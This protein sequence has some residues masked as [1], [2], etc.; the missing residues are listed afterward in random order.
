[1]ANGSN[2]GGRGGSGGIIMID[3]ASKNGAGNPTGL[4]YSMTE[5]LK[6]IVSTL[7]PAGV[8]PEGVAQRV[9]R[10]AAVWQRHARTRRSAGDASGDDSSHLQGED[11]IIWDLLK[12]WMVMEQRLAIQ[13]DDP[14][15]EVSTKIGDHVV[16]DGLQQEDQNNG[17][18]H[19]VA[20]MMVSEYLIPPV[21][22]THYEEF[23][24]LPPV[25]IPAPNSKM[26]QVLAWDV[27]PKPP[28]RSDHSEY[29]ETNDILP[30][31]AISPVDH[32]PPDVENWD[33]EM[34]GRDERIVLTTDNYPEG[35]TVEPEGWRWSRRLEPTILL[36]LPGN[37]SESI[38]SPWQTFSDVLSYRGPPV[39][40]ID[41]IVNTDMLQCQ[42][43][44][45]TLVQ[46]TESTESAFQFTESS[47]IT[48]STQTTQSTDYTI[49]S[50]TESNSESPTEFILST[51][52]SSESYTESTT[53]PFTESTTEFS[54][55]TA[56]RFNSETTTESNLESTTE[57]TT[58]S[59][60]YTEF[61]TESTT[62][63][64]SIQTIQTI[65]STDL[66]TETPE[67]TGPSETTET[68]KI[69]ATLENFETATSE[70][71]TR[72]VT[73]VATSS[74]ATPSQTMRPIPPILILEGEPVAYV[75][76]QQLLYDC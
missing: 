38:L 26:I 73:T 1:M 17:N 58:E 3:N 12:D 35:V 45:P 25:Q 39:D 18:Q 48:E 60:L 75:I 33:D 23:I 65:Q 64:E 44:C 11:E 62:L 6:F 76:Y 27:E 15:R 16:L 21:K 22:D 56:T 59:T 67:T 5:V 63:T 9:D 10:L 20:R 69:L 49:E 7:D 74:M 41:N 54:S 28:E 40:P 52:S 47:L 19:N 70:T 2:N 32:Q 61:A 51:E 30:P 57:S 24:G 72:L 13:A 14:R 31:G 37:I 36:S 71:T 66:I 8:K 43:H 29:Q 50:S 34:I 68:P 55:E 53:E 42:C 4:S 46:S